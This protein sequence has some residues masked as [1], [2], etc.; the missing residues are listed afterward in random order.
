[1]SLSEPTLETNSQTLNLFGFKISSLEDTLA[2]TTPI[3][4]DTLNRTTDLKKENLEGYIFDDQDLEYLDNELLPDF[5]NSPIYKSYI[6]NKPEAHFET[7]DLFK[8]TREILKTYSGSSDMTKLPGN[9]H[10]KDLFKIAPPR[11]EL[12]C[13][14]F[15]SA[16]IRVY[17]ALATKLNRADLLQRSTLVPTPNN[18]DT[19]AS[20]NFQYLS[21]HGHLNIVVLSGNKISLIDPYHSRW[22]G[23]NSD[24]DF[25]QRRISDIYVGLNKIFNGSSI[26][27]GYDSLVRSEDLGLDDFLQLVEAKVIHPHLGLVAILYYNK[28]YYYIETAAKRFKGSEDGFRFAQSAY[29]FN[30][31]SN[32]E[33]FLLTR[34][35]KISLD[36]S[37]TEYETQR[38]VLNNLRT[39]QEKVKSYIKEVLSGSLDEKVRM[40][41]VDVLKY[42]DIKL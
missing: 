30:L 16:F 8:L 25:T 37:R 23:I 9:L 28:L 13:V 31:K 36:K 14:I 21:L 15:N 3:N 5:F 22:N 7:L 42:Y 38:E 2:N 39:M 27:T 17:E 34:N 40:Y 18:F 10:F 20:Y 24:F 33:N 6:F 12:R 41:I 32:G 26:L 29:D 4:P 1:M 19:G 11:P 35:S